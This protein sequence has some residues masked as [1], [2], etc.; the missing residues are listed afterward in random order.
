MKPGSFHRATSRSRTG[1]VGVGFSRFRKDGK[2]V[3]FFTANLG[4]RGVRKFNI[5]RMGRSEAF[6][7]AVAA[8]AHYET[9]ATA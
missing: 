8:R 5:D 9:G 6:R 3:N 7:S 2:L 1:V 4:P